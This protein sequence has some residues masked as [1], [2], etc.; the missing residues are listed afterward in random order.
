[1]PALTRPRF[2][3]D[4]QA[5]IL[6]C[7]SGRNPTMRHIGRV[8]GV[9]VQWMND[10]LG[11]HARRDNVNM[12]YQDTNFMS[13]DIYT[14]AF[15]TAFK[16]KRAQLLIS[17][18]EEEDLT[19][20]RL[21]SWFRDLHEKANAPDPDIAL[22]G[23][24]QKGKQKEHSSAVANDC[25]RTDWFADSEM[26]CSAPETFVDTALFLECAV[27]VDCET[28]IDSGN[29]DGSRLCCHV[30][31]CMC[32]ACVP[33]LKNLDSVPGG[34]RSSNIGLG[35]KVCF[36]NLPLFLPWAAVF[37]PDNS[38]MASSAEQQA[39]PAPATPGSGLAAKD[40]IG[41][42]TMTSEDCWEA[43]AARAKQAAVRSNRDAHAQRSSRSSTHD[44]WSGNVSQTA[45][46]KRGW[47]ATQQHIERQG[48]V[49]SQ[50]E[51]NLADNKRERRE[52]GLTAASN[53]RF[54]GYVSQSAEHAIT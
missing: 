13:A 15:D 47:F 51:V 50:S 26:G 18:F 8:H 9:S 25:P 7:M 43:A 6:V 32:S 20:E 42:S 44:S 4:N 29:T 27:A 30:D 46:V 22:S 53:R 48:N 1:M 39:T 35:Q 40:D 31:S 5:M 19:P 54:A 10:R 49:I 17:H 16:G 24:S 28:T 21:G 33:L 14:K 45:E 38:A 36:D 37:G 3:E 23:W 12:F 52:A 2:H 41:W 34:I 11:P